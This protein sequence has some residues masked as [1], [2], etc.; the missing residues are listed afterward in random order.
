MSGPKS[1]SYTL[2][3]EAA[4]RL[5]AARQQEEEER[6]R[7]DEERQRREAEAR[8]RAEEARR[9]ERSSA[10]ENGGFG[11]STSRLQFLDTH[12]C[13]HEIISPHVE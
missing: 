6:R 3:A 13:I 4:E 1:A 11:Y 2:S 12:L 9:L 8:A 10:I 7:A 5:R